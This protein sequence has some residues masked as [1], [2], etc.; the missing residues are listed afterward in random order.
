MQMWIKVSNY[1]LPH[2]FT[3]FSENSWKIEEIY[4]Q[5]RK[6]NLNLKRNKVRKVNILATSNFCIL[7]VCA[8][9]HAVVKFY[10]ECNKLL[11]C[12]DEIPYGTIF[13]YFFFVRTRHKQHVKLYFSS[14]CKEIQNLS[15]QN[16]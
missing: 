16:F 9:N 11:C 2:E 1:L 13:F 6:K 10:N 5:K 14:T 15:H 12:L 8:F 4:W 3:N 7:A